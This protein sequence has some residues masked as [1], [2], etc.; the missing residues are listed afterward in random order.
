MVASSPV[1][2]PDFRVLGPLEVF[3]EGKQV[4]VPAG[5]QRTL[6]GMLLLSRGRA[7]SAT[8][9]AEGLW[10]EH[11][12]MD[13]R[14][15]LHTAVARLRRTLGGTGEALRTLAP[16]YV[17]DIPREALDS[18]RFSDLHARARTLLGHPA[19]RD[20]GEARATEAVLVLRAALDLW[21]GPAWGELADGVASGDAL[22]LEE[23]RLA[24]REDLATALVYA[25]QVAEAVEVLETVVL[26]DPLRDRAV[27]LLV[28]ALH[29]HGRTADA[30]HTFEI[31][32][33][34]LAEELGLDPSPTLA[35]LHQRVLR[36]ELP[37][38]QARSTA[39]S[40]VP[41]QRS[42]SGASGAAP[43]A[44]DTGPSRGDLRG[45]LIGRDEDAADVS[46]LLETGGL[47]TLVGPGG[48]GKSRLAEHIA[49]RQPGAS[50]WVDLVPARDRAGV[51]QALADTLG[52][53]VRS[54]TA[55]ENAV[56]ERLASDADL[57]V[58][59][60][61]EHVL[62]GV[63]AVLS[64]L[65]T[66]AATVLATSRERL[67][68]VGERVY[69]LDPLALPEPGVADAQAPAVQLFLARAADAGVDLGGD[70]DVV[71]RV[72]EVCRALDGL[73]L[74]LELGAARMG[75]LTLDDL[76]ERLDRRFELLTRGPRTA[77]HRHQTLRSVVGWSYDL[78]DDE[79]RQV[80][81][82]L[83]VFP[84]G[85]DL[86]A[87]EAVVVDEA[88]DTARVADVVARLADRSM[89]V[90]PSGAGRGKYRLLESLRRYGASRL[91]P[92]DVAAVRRRHALW[93]TDLAERSRRGLESPE[94]ARWTAVLDDV[95]DD[96]KAAW[97]WTQEAE[98]PQVAERLLTAVCW[99]AYWR[100]RADVLCWGA[101][102]VA[103]QP[104]TAPPVAYTTAAACAWLE[105]DFEEAERVADLAAARY[106]E[107]SRS[108]LYEILGDVYLSRSAVARAVE[109]YA[110][111]ERIR[112]SSGDRIGESIAASNKVLGLAYAD[113]PREAAVAH[114]LE[115]AART[116][117]PTALAFAR[118]AQGEAW[119]ERDEH[120]AVGALEEALVL[121]ESVGNRLI[122]GVAM[123]ALVALRGR[124]TSVEPATFELFGR[125][126]LHWSTAGNPT[127]MV[128]A[129][130][131]L[132]ILLGR[133]GRDEEAVELWAAVSDMDAL[134]PSYGAEAERLDTTLATAR[135]RL[136]SSFEDAVHRGHSH[137]G[138]AAVT[139]LACRVCEE[140]AR[141]LATTSTGVMTSA[142]AGTSA[143]IHVGTPPTPA[144]IGPPAARDV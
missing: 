122:I 93:A 87:A 69:V 86:A 76:A 136:G 97:R 111:A 133:V 74:A 123:T 23:A 142:G 125:V 121:A 10:G 16:G 72:G 64:S 75:T 35:A 22:R 57:V 71:R 62:D 44:R 102:Q 99:W 141:R 144:P 117:S 120:R 42:A 2:G 78:L 13:P 8:R 131:N 100:L 60:N 130:R 41:P 108:G 105:G 1:P 32:R 52:V 104:T 40:R 89:V 54:G 36:Q 67:G 18:D 113:L 84:S 20:P 5:T 65:V 58:L 115:L 9:L 112:A 96:L 90:R 43:A 56:Y 79:E 24:A 29:R 37:E 34:V 25:G 143:R 31:Y 70:P 98:E 80:F 88:L 94:E 110:H 45:G 11:Q 101:Q 124:S 118:Y 46:E 85:F 135:S 4:P 114:A 15:S 82:R 30:L 19:G 127:L 81:T 47:V 39:P 92:D 66:P 49:Q 73:P 129:L 95:L 140:E 12:P 17:L 33:E 48:V 6:L 53:E 63:A 138:L 51:L 103:D 83:S 109:S 55:M 61:C 50:C 132:V 3:L 134:H 137:T 28:D 77:P 128:T 106:D 91:A 14:A 139:A 21:H 68:V 26:E 107:E 126:V 38:P 116:G 119:A 27:G 59:D 7:V